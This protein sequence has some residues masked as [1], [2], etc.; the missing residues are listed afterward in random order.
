MFS[1]EIFTP[2]GTSHGGSTRPQIGHG[3]PDVEG[4]QTRAGLEQA[5]LFLLRAESGILGDVVE[6]MG[7]RVVSEA[8]CGQTA[9]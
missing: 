5:C 1:T 3:W 2:D 9:A 7:D 6:D 8:A 4:R